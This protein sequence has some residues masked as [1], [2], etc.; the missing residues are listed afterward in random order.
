MSASIHIRV[1]ALGRGFVAGL[2][3]CRFARRRRRRNSNT[4]LRFGHCGGGGEER[5]FAFCA[6]HSDCD[7][8]LLLLRRRRLVLPRPSGLLSVAIFLMQ[9][10]RK[11][12]GTPRGEGGE[13]QRC[14]ARA[15]AGGD[16]Q[17]KHTARGPSNPQPPNPRDRDKSNGPAGS[18]PNAAPQSASPCCC[19]DWMKPL[20]SSSSSSSPCW[21][22]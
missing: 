11:V 15:A 18:E 3:R 10:L 2:F 5:S 8:L 1:V 22:L 7:W 17:S 4:V 16:E 14:V 19:C 9:L 12:D 20:P 21:T 13:G 6:G